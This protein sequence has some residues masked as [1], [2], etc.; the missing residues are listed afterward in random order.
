V[1]YIDFCELICGT[2][3]EFCEVFCETCDICDVCEETCEICVVREIC[4]I[5]DIYVMIL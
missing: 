2:T 4:G 3:S 5:G 1:K